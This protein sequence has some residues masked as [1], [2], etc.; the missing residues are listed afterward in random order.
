[1]YGGAKWIPLAQDKVVDKFVN[2]FIKTRNFSTDYEN[3]KFSDKV[4]TAWSLLASY[5]VRESGKRDVPFGLQT[6]FENKIFSRLRQHCKDKHYT[7]SKKEKR[8][9]QTIKH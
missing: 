3:V 4:L 9:P 7:P 8:G 2:N 1:M 5:L 6:M